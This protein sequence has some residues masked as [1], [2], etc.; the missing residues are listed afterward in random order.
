MGTQEDIKSAGTLG[1]VGS[2]LMFI[3]YVSIIGDILVLIALNKLSK[4][5]GNNA[6]WSNALYALVTAII[7]GIILAFAFAGTAYLS[8]IYLGPSALSRLG[9]FIVVFVVFYIIILISGLFMRNAYNELS[10]SSGVEDFGSAARWYWL[11]AILTIIIVGFILYIVA[12]I[13]ALL[14]YSKL[15]G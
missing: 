3:P 4:A 10:R 14:G 6:I 13:Y 1:F 12:D 9:M 8:L 5:Y 15:R 7:G 2:I 11:G